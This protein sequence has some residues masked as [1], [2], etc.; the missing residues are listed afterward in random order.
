MNLVREENII[1]GLCAKDYVEALEKLSSLL[2]SNGVA[3]ES[4]Q[5]AV[6][7]RERVFPTG[8]E[9]EGLGVALPHTD[10]EHVNR[11]SIGVATLKKPVEFSMMGFPEKSV[12]VSIVI[13]LAISNPNGHLEILQKLSDLLQNPKMLEEIYLSEDKQFILNYL[14]KVFS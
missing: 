8:L 10:A 11:N 12:S 2:L 1:L 3:K 4:F 7:E 14:N 5:N 9:T 6:L 13:M